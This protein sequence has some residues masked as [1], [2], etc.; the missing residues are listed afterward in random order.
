MWLTVFQS[1]AKTLRRLPQFV[2][3]WLYAVNP[4]TVSLVTRH[5]VEPHVHELPCVVPS[6][7]LGL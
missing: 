3:D 5:D 1:P 4:D 7:Q 6:P 2:H